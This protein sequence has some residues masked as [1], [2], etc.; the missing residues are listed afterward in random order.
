[1]FRTMVKSKIHRAT[2]T[3]ADL[4]YIGSLT[5]DLDLLDA[6]DLIAGEQVHVVNVTNGARLVTYLIEGS[7][8]PGS[9]A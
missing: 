6:A 7:A 9:S 4:N 8:A 1:M 2:V 3:Q 5:V